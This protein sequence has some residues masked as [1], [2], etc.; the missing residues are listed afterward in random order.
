MKQSIESR[1]AQMR[2]DLRHL[3]N[4]FN[5]DGSYNIATDGQYTLQQLASFSDTLSTY[6][7]DEKEMDWPAVQTDQSR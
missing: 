2:A 6:G 5:V 3:V 4:H 7:E 1:L